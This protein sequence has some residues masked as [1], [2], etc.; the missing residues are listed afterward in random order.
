M[1]CDVYFCMYFH[2]LRYSCLQKH[3]D[4][5]LQVHNA[6]G[7]VIQAGGKKDYVWIIFTSHKKI[8]VV[9]THLNLHI[10]A[11]NNNNI[12]MFY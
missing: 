9:G 10:K 5:S 11:T 2:D 8:Y 6:I 3:T 12:K 1:A 4:S 7:Q